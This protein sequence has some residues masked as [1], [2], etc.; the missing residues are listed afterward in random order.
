MSSSGP[1]LIAFRA[2]FGGGFGRRSVFGGG[3]GRRRGVF[4]S[5]RGRSR[6]FLHNVA[7]FLA[8][9][10]LLH[11]FFSHGGLSILLWLIVIGLVV[12]FV[13]RRRR[14]YAY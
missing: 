3:F 4:G 14:R 2:H 11:L 8:F 1:R 10:F 12:H 5:R 13:R 7:R 9:S 6:G